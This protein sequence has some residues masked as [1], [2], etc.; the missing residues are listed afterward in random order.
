MHGNWRS[1]V[2]AYHTQLQAKGDEASTWFRLGKAY[3]RCFEWQSAA[4]AYRAAL[5]IEKDRTYWRYRLGFVLERAGALEQAAT[6]Y[7][8]AVAGG[9]GRP[10]VAFRLG[11]VRMQLGLYREACE[12]FSASFPANTG[13]SA[14]VDQAAIDGLR[15]QL[16]RDAQ[17][18]D[19]W[20][21]L[22]DAL[23]QCAVWREAAEAWSA[24]IDRT[25]RHR[26]AWYS[27]L[28]SA[29]YA[30]GDYES[31]ARAFAEMR[32]FKR[33]GYVRSRTARSYTMGVYAELLETVVLRENVILYESFFG[34]AITCSPYALFRQ[35]LAYPFRD[36]LLHVWVVNGHTPVPQWMR[37]LH[38]V[39]FV[40]KDSDGY[41]RYL[42]TAGHL[43]NN[44]TFPKEFVRRPG[45]RYL[46]TWHGTPI[47]TLGRHR[48]DAFFEHRNV[49][50]NLLQATH[51]IMPNGF[52]TD[53]LLDAYDI[54]SLIPGRIAETGY[55]RTDLTLNATDET[56][57]ALRLRLGLERGEPVVLYAPTWRGVL[58]DVAFEID[59]VI[60]DVGRLAALPVQVLFRGHH[61]VQGKMSGAASRIRVVPEDIPT[62][63]LLSVVDIL[64]TDYS[65]IVF[66]FLVTRRPVLY[67][68]H[69]LED[70]R[71]DVGMY[72]SM[73]DLPGRQC[74]DIGQ[75]VAELGQLVSDLDDWAP[76]R[77]YDAAC[78]RF[79][80]HDDGRVSSRVADWFFADG[81]MPTLVDTSHKPRTVLMYAGGWLGNGVTMSFLNFLQ[82]GVPGG[83]ET[84]IAIDPDVV[85]SSRINR[86]LFERIPAEYRV[87]GRISGMVFTPEEAWLHR[88]YLRKKDLESSSQWRVLENAFVREYRRMFG[89]A[90]FEV[91]VNYDGYGD[92][93]AL[94]F[95]FAPSAVRRKLI[96]QHNDMYGE[97][98]L[99]FPALAAIFRLYHRYDALVSTARST[100]ELNQRNLAPLFDLEPRQFTWVQLTIDWQH[101]LT[102]AEV[103]VTLDED[104][105][106]MV[107]SAKGPLL[108]TVG[109]LSPEKDHHKLLRA[110]ARIR[111]EFPDARLIIVGDG[112]LRTDME[113]WIEEL[114]VGDAVRLAGYLENPFPIVKAADVFVFS[115]NYEGLGVVLLEALV[116]GRQVVST[117]IP[118]CRDALEGGNGLLVDNSEDGLVEGV[119][120]CLS[121]RFHAKA[122]DPVAW[123]QA[124]RRTFEERVY[125]LEMRT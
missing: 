17:N 45:Q 97:W 53:R 44:V 85:E 56:K 76:D 8:M 67:Y 41:W 83:F 54:R 60:E 64:I 99:R 86:N 3:E 117:N 109:R 110:F 112:P 49:A 23:E 114:C 24:A 91:L 63:E 79:C 27:R 37:S 65:S 38:N 77:A 115:S 36:D 47:K 40:R 50:R 103:P 111:R 120:A 108:V 113:N 13:G 80:P 105:A 5:A 78:Q 116:L 12:A 101:V 43:V 39:V 34:A 31:A 32:R 125:G 29:L 88:L 2:D 102:R 69:D 26:P 35:V 22:G 46:F 20:F 61:L 93:W 98:C 107:E 51:A 11:W 6:A 94:L 66:D 123:N 19:L 30:S 7:A 124:S 100:C 84:T 81:V 87:F 68:V 10:G 15:A 75:L 90:E 1:A 33:A 58:N 122:F 48:R 14:S 72:L 73:D 42:A 82:G 89:E 52:T 4:D 28:G 57:Q 92:Y 119:R 18:P 70:Y 74:H 21:R 104:I 62:N 71:R 96:F 106:A 59:R 9:Q 121:G 16:Q 118:G 55:P 95:A 25:D